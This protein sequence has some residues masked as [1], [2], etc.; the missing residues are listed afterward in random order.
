ME[1]NQNLILKKWKYFK[2]YLNR[3]K[4]YR[5]QYKFKYYFDY[6]FIKLYL[7]DWF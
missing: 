4:M 3:G 6:Y 7:F 1:E 5:I 2:F